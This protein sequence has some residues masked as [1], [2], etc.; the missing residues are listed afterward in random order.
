MGDLA[1]EAI[2]AEGPSLE[3]D[4]CRG[5]GLNGAPMASSALEPRVSSSVTPTPSDPVLLAEA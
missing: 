1:F 3:T 5:D 4:A 2:T